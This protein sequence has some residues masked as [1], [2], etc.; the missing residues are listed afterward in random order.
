MKRA[1]ILLNMGGPNS[2][3]EV[4]V[5]L[6]NMF[7]DPYIMSPISNPILRFLLSRLIPIMRLNSAKQNYLAIGGSSPLAGITDKLCKEIASIDNG[8]YQAIDFA[9]RY[10]PPFCDDVFRR[11]LEFD[12]IVLLP[13]YPQFSYS[14]VASSLDDA[15]AS[16]K[17]L[18]FKGRV[19]ETGEFYQQ[20]AY[21]EILIK[22]AIQALE[23]QD[24]KQCELIFSAHSLPLKM[25]ELGDPYASQSQEQASI[26]TAMLKERGFS[27]SSSTLAYQS[28][29]GP[30]KWLSPATSEV[31]KELKSKRALLL[32]ISFCI[33]NSETVFELDIEYKELAKEL[34]YEFYKVAKCPND[35]KDF[36]RFL[37]D[38][39]AS[40]K[41]AQI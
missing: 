41:V 15:K 13:L 30:I 37:L 18:G 20:K 25:I 23:G 9:M 16:L 35:S 17:R 5:F 6:K 40:A 3:D 29:L 10:T 12:E 7:K 33:D 34:G 11:Y 22:L 28:K 39:S 2:L 26:L 4:G 32:P 14:T 24:P 8:T 21:N 38:F 1:L 36:A 27:F 19:L 31:I